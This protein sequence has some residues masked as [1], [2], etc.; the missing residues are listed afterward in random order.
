M[1][2]RGIDVKQHFPV[3]S[4][5]CLAGSMINNT[6]YCKPTLLGRVDV[7][8]HLLLVGKPTLLGKVDVKWHLPLS[9]LRCLVE[10]MLSDTLHWQATSLFDVSP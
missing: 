6:F 7:K 10:S 5:R 4:L 9:S 8:Q 1:L 2:V 3:V